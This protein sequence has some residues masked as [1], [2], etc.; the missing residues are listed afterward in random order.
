MDTC[1]KTDCINL[2]DALRR[3]PSSWPW[4]CAA[5]I[6]IMDQILKRNPQVR[7]S[8]IPRS[9][10]GIADRIAKAA[11]S[12]T[13]PEIESDNVPFNLQNLYPYHFPL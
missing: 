2:V 11:A 8:F 4:Q 1:V 3:N 5:W 7:V 10:N 6:Q 9:L 12:G 13:L